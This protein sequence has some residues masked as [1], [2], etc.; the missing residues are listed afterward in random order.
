[1]Y[2]DLMEPVVP[3]LSKPEGRL[4]QAVERAGYDTAAEFA[5][6][7]GMPAATVRS[8]MNGTRNITAK[9]AQRFSRFL[10]VPAE[11]L[12]YGGTI[13]ESQPPT[14]PA[15]PIPGATDGLQRH[16]RPLGPLTPGEKNLPIR[17][18]AKGGA[19]GFFL[20][21]GEL[22]GMTFRPE[23]LAGV[24]DAYALEMWNDSMHP[25]LKHGHL[26]LVHPRKTPMPG[27]DV[28]VILKDGQVLAKEL[29]RRTEK[30]LIL[31]QWNPA[32]ELRLDMS[33]VDKIHLIVDSPRVR[34]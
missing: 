12:L 29:V 33:K 16:L 20:D 3:D 13:S 24:K 8:L 23:I 34:V 14:E 32:E 4:Q 5:K 9:T 17:G 6:A 19:E 27:D 10:R 7:V 11:W 18:F 31:R 2:G 21:Q 22:A 25:A 26:I 15:V 28:L 1:M 30:F